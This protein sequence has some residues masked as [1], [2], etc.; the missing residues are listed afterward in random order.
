MKNDMEVCYICDGPLHKFMTTP[1]LEL[2]NGN[3]VQCCEKC[4]NREFP[5]WNEYIKLAY[6]GCECEV[7]HIEGGTV[8]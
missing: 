2:P 5:G 1:V 6:Q 3:L 4:A 7:I 8:E